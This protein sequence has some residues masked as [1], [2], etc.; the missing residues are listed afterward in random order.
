[1][2]RGASCWSIVSTKDVKQ[3]GITPVL[4]D[5]FYRDVIGVSFG[6]IGSLVHPKLKDFHPGSGIRQNEN[7]EN[8]PYNMRQYLLK[9]RGHRKYFGGN[10]KKTEK[11]ALPPIDLFRRSI[12]IV[13]L[14]DHLTYGASPVTQTHGGS[15]TH[16]S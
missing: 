1:M 7:K 5:G 10:K 8:P 9:Y 14:C 12:N 2:Q 13:Y 16:V 15:D 6:R 3:N 4:A 11:F